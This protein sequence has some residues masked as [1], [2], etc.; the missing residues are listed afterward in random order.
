MNDQDP[1]ASSDNRL[2]E[3]ESSLTPRGLTPG[4]SGA[5]TGGNRQSRQPTN[6]PQQ[7]KIVVRVARAEAPS[8]EAPK[9]IA[10]ISAP[11]VS[12]PPPSPDATLQTPVPPETSERKVR[13]EAE[14]QQIPARMLNEFVYCHFR[15]NRKNISESSPSKF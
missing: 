1:S 12:S 3:P 8:S 9:P 13:A 15:L 7:L 2:S 4:T 5:R 11:P 6:E 10:E 14:P